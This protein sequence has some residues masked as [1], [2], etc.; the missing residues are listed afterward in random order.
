MNDTTSEPRSGTCSSC[1]GPVEITGEVFSREFAIR[2][3]SGSR[4]DAEWLRAIAVS[5]EENPH[6]PPATEQ[7]ARLRAIAD[8]LTP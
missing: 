8:R 4:E 1:G 5:V 6:H 3:V 7:V 2:H